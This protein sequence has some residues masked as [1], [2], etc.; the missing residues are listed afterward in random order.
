MILFI[1]NSRKKKSSH[2]KHTSGCLRLGVVGLE[3]MDSRRKHFR[4]MKMCYF[5]IVVVAWSC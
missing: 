3:R 2:R 5:L 1:R 4:V